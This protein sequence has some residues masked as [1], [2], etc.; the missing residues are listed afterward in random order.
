M[1]PGPNDP[2][3]GTFVRQLEL[4]LRQRGHE[5]E[6]AVL[7]RRAG[8]KRRYLELARRVRRARQPDV[9]YAHFLVPAGWLASRV[10]APLVV[11]AHG[12]DVRNVGTIPGVAAL[13]RRVV[14]RAAAVIA[15]SDYLRRELE[16]KVPAAR[17][18]T[19]VVDSGV[20]LDRF[21]PSQ[22][23]KCHLDSPAFL[24]V[25]A[26]SER[27]NVVRLADA[28]AR[29]GEG[30]LAFVGDGP[31][32]ARLEHRERVRVVGRVPHDEIPGWIASA[33][34][35]CQPSL[36]EPFGQ[37]LLEALACGRS[38]V[39][40]RLGGPPEFVPAEA[41]VL[42]DPTDLDDLEHGLR[43]AAALPRPN[44]AARAAAAEHD[45][46]R[47]AARIEAILERAAAGPRA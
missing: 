47:Q 18:K 44:E 19:H 36:L 8:G 32:R 41:G 40:T 31:L 26:L 16:A 46:R 43:L 20:D 23:A 21:S 39:A 2:D 4:A 3:L 35:V 28:F 11:T 7:D 15:V 1:Y 10:D 45:V 29:L 25:G 37:S 5:L 6:L 38:V 24:C 34:V 12:R 14:T 9:V 17:G 13:T 33:D 30:S 42:V 27:K 22:V